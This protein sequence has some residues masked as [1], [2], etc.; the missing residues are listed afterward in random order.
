[1]GPNMGAAI[2]SAR[3]F[4]HISEPGIFITHH[5]RGIGQLCTV[6]YFKAG[7][8][9]NNRRGLIDG[10]NGQAIFLITLLVLSQPLLT[11]I[12]RIA[13]KQ[14]SIAPELTALKELSKAL[15]C[16]SQYLI[17]SKGDCICHAVKAID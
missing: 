2:R 13:V 4:H 16:L 17:V 11:L 14:L 10:D 7:N 15:C 6:L 1:M 8:G 5:T 9:I 12:D 3:L